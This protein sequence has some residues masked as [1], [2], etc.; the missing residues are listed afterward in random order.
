[1]V[2]PPATRAEEGLA[3]SEGLEET[4]RLECDV[5]QYDV[6]RGQAEARGGVQIAY[7]DSFMEAEEVFLD[8]KQRTSYSR[9]R[10]RLLH[11]GDI[12]RCESLS[13]H[14]E[15]Q[16]GSLEDGEVLFEDTGYNIHAGVLE[17]TGVDTYLVE[18]GRFTTCQCPSS[19]DRLPWEVRARKGEVT[20]GGYAKIRRAS[21]FLYNIPVLYLPRMYLPVK[22]QRESGFLTPSIGQSGSNGWEFYLPFF[23]AI[24]ASLDTTF[25]LGGLTKRGVKPSWE[26]RYR[27]SKR[28][29]G[30]WVFNA[31]EDLKDERFR[32]S[33]AATH[34]QQ[35]TSAYYNKVEFKLVSDNDYTEDFAEEVGHSA[36]R[37]V[38]SR[39]IFGF[40]RENL[41]ATL[42][43]NFTD[44]VAVNGGKDVPQRLPH[45]HVDLVHRPLAFP[46]LSFGWRSEA[47]HFLNEEGDQRV[48]SQVFP[49]GSVRLRLMPGLSLAGRVGVREIVSQGVDDGFG[50]EG[51]QHRTLVEETVDLEGTLGRNYSWG[52]YGLHHLVRPKLQYQWIEKLA[53][54]DF[55]VVMDGLDQHERRNWVT[56]SLYSSLW[57]AKRNDRS[58]G[59]GGMLAEARVAQSIDLRR[60]ETD[61]PSQRL[62]SD[63]RTNIRLRPRPYLALGLDLQVDP[64][65][66]SMRSLETRMSLSDR[67]NRYGLRVGYLYHRPHRVD[68]VTRVELWD[69][70]TLKYPFEGVEKT[71]STGMHAK[72][73]WQWS[74]SLETLYLIESSGKVANNFSVS[75]RSACKCWSVL[76]RLRQTVRPDDVG[77]SVHFQLEGLGSQF[78]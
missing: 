52:S 38:E 75:Y 64:Y 33:L 46:W 56:Y 66:G 30:Q 37:V 17:K 50:E 39:G 29:E 67:T 58:Q 76:L 20:L 48:R 19:A 13:F 43:G 61:S 3:G 70:Y 15:T 32:Y 59:G 36:D 71:V 69:A 16:T 7:E 35:I 77:F 74:A 14:W 60:D 49:Q 68:P 25:T 27:P 21:F 57:G 34:M 44:P 62:L 54:D 28:T 18:E 24:N 40:R 41:H 6:S 53:S 45:V 65:R 2:C 12:L 9:G 47:I 55:P 10:V 26:F 78:Q 22:V 4:L 73:T 31:I 42:E 72:L 63:L 1:M 8:I 51:T 23:Y 11:H 5:L